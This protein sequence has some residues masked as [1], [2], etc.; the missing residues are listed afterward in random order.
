MNNFKL[1]KIINEYLKINQYKDCVPNGLQVEGVSIVKKIIT[2]VT[3]SQ[4]LIDQSIKL[5][6]DAIIVHHGFFWKNEP[7]QILNM[8]KKRIKKLLCNNINLYSY[9]LPLDAHPIVGNNAQ[10]G[11][12]INIKKIS[13][14]CP[15]LPIG[16]LDKSIKPKKFRKKLQKKFKKK[17]FYIENKEKKIKKIAWCTGSGQNLLEKAAQAGADAFVTGEVSEKIFHIAKEMN[18]NFYSLGHHTTEIYG[19]QALGEWLKKK[20]GFLV[21]FINI[22]NPI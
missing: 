11:N 15:I 22:F 16:Q 13:Y 4:D 21:N 5:K 8:K 12:L 18:I 17:P 1:E 20:Y 6:T 14:I 2:G 7:V 3:A 10:L 19:I 9:H